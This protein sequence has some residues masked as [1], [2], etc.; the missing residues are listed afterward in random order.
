M[1]YALSFS[2]ASSTT[3]L[4]TCTDIV[5]GLPV[6]RPVHIELATPHAGPLTNVAILRNDETA[7]CT[8][9]SG[10]LLTPLYQ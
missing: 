1:F 9:G 3:L 2:I 8:V 5:A 10:M 6:A 4:A 7:V